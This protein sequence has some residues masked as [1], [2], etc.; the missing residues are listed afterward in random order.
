MATSS[1][2]LVNKTNYTAKD[3]STLREELLQNIPIMTGGRW[4]NLNES[5]PGITILEIFMSMVDN[6]LFYMDMQG[7]EVDLNKARQRTSVIKL[8]R[9][10]GYEVNG[11]SGSRGTVTIQVSPNQNVIYP[12]FIEKGTQL[13]AQGQN[14]SLTFTTLDSVTLSNATDTRT[15]AVIQGVSATD[16]YTS[17]G[18]PSQKVILSST[19]ADKSS[20]KVYVDEESTDSD[21]IS[22]NK[23]TSFYK[24]TFSSKDY[25]IQTDEYNRIVII[26]GDGQFGQIPSVNKAITITYVIADGAQGN[27]GKNAITQVSSGVPFVKDNTSNKVALSVTGSS[28]TAGGSDVE[29]I[30]QAKETATGLLFG[31]NRALSRDDYKALMLSVP[32][33]SKAVAWGENEEQTPDYRMMNRVRASFFSISFYD[34]FY[35]EASRAS[36]RSLRDN[37]VRKLLLERMPI[38]TRLVFVD[39]VLSDIFV[40]VQVGININKY[41]PNIVVDEIRTTLLNSYSLENVS[42]GQDIRISNLLSLANSVEGVSWARITRLYTTPVTSV[43]DVA[44][45]PPIDIV[46]EKWKLPTFSDTTLNSSIVQE[47]VQIS[48]PYILAAAPANFNLGQND[49]IVVN[50]DDQSDILANGYVYYPGSNL[51]HINISY[52][53]ITDEPSPQGGYYGHPNPE[54]DYTTYSSLD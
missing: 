52:T 53:A 32:G 8:L 4:T 12:V 50:P 17:D 41:D 14:V 18:T 34:M 20:I 40:S 23:V 5:D 31:L 39:P 54:S 25:K 30:E 15:V 6:L 21:A 38:T 48:P 42:F 29:S 44:P 33:V 37:Q 11:V 45:Q 46:L 43:P 47:N 2:S 1:N 3:Y 10:I 35:N 16:T 22:W 28:A 49:V 13:T 26:F 36:Y 7:Q 9:L 19:N 51:Q 27:V 24:S